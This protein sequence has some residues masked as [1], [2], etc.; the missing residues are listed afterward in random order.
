[1]SDTKDGKIVV[2]SF[3]CN[4]LRTESICS[5]GQ[6]DRGMLIIDSV[7]EEG[8][9]DYKH[10]LVAGGDTMKDTLRKA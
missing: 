5:C 2:F 8:Q 6:A 10:F 9:F 3:A 1:M 7:R 4:F